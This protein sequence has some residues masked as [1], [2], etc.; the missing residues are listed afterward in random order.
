MRIC[1]VYDCIYPHTVGGAERWYRNLAERLAADGHEVDYLTL[2]QWPAG[3]DAGV[4]GV[5]VIAVGPR[6]ALYAGGRRRIGP[7]LRFGLGV[8]LHL[9]RNRR[10]YDVVHTASFP[11]FSL[12]A[13]GRCR[14]LR[15]LPAR[16]R[17]A[18]GLDARL[19]ARVPRGPSAVAAGWAVQRLCLRI[20]RR[21][22][23]FSRLH[24]RR[25]ARARPARRADGAPRTIRR[26]ARAAI[27]GGRA[28]DGRLRGASH[29]R[30]ARSR[31]RAGVSRRARDG[32]PIFVLSSSGMAPNA[33][34]CCG[35]L[36]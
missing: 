13:A 1:L 22:F 4:P 17:L 30:E 12:L 33:T 3:E 7:P 15:Q 32:S 9:A 21:S 23:C 10:R 6:M 2:R 27:A 18:R 26:A 29:S 31:A 25:L 36:P 35:S 20:P 16:R 28:A 24:E 5:N 8:F 11:Y 14:P 19:L 34:R